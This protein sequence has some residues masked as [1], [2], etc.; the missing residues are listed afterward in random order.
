MKNLGALIA[1]RNRTGM[2][3]MEVL[4]A[5]VIAATALLGLTYFFVESAENMRI[6][7]Q[8]RNMEEF[9]YYYTD[10]F[11]E[12]IRNGYEPQIV[13]VTAPSELEVKYTDPWDP[14]GKESVYKFEFDRR[15]GLP[16]MMKDG[17]VIEYPDFPPPSPDTRD[18]FVILD[19]S[20]LI[21]N[22]DRGTPPGIDP[23][24]FA[25]NYVPNYFKLDFT[26]VYR[27][28]PVLGSRGI[29]EREVPF[30]SGAWVMS[31]KWQT[32]PDTTDTDE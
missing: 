30:S 25:T 23:Q 31:S 28:Y 12:K 19:D 16:V 15:S 20:F 9:G 11:R 2:M 5:I 3:L 24:L 18:E 4:V 8:I 22:Y 17:V 26:M 32:E 27:R 29:F 1:L 21:T 14:I 6:A 13:R 7:W 10:Q